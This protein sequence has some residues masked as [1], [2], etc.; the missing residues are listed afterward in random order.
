[1]ALTQWNGSERNT[2]CEYS[3]QLTK[4]AEADLDDILGYMTNEL[5]NDVTPKS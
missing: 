3:F 5:T 1:M 4:T 2:I